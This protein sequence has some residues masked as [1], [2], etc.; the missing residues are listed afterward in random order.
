MDVGWL[1]DIEAERLTVS[2]PKSRSP[3]TA[4]NGNNSQSGNSKE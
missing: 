1:C 3:S 2:E 4:G